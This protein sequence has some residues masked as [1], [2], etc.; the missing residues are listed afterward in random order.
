MGAA[1]DR[2][3]GA[4]LGR[5]ALLERVMNVETAALGVPTGNQDY[6][7]AVHGGGPGG[8]PYFPYRSEDGGQFFFHLEH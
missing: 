8:F 3:T 2:F 7:A 4:S 1:L 6:L 5:A